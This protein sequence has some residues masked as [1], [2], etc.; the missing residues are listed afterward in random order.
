MIFV[1]CGLM[2]LV[3]VLVLVLVL[4]TKKK[5]KKLVQTK[6]NQ[7]QVNKSG[8]IIKIRNRKIQEPFDRYSDLAL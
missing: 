6:P 5:K 7:N 3:L 4:R 2:K 8:T 1:V